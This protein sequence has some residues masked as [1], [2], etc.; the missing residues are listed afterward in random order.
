MPRTFNTTRAAS[1][2]AEANLKPDREVAQAFGVGVRTIEYWRN[3]LKW[4]EQLQQE[5]KAM[6]KGKLNHW[7]TKI[8]D[9][10]DSAIDFI[11]KAAETGD[12]TNPEMV[13]AVTGAIGMLNEVLIIQ[14]AIAA[15]KAHT[16]IGNRN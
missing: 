4:D 2:L 16:V 14:D 11:M 10:L 7:T 15:R 8:P 12:P 3:R 13:R 6:S 5:Y 9:C 1:A